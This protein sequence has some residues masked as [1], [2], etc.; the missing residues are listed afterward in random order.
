MTDIEPVTTT[1]YTLQVLLQKLSYI[2]IWC[3][4]KLNINYDLKL[5]SFLTASLFMFYELPAT[6]INVTLPAKGRCVKNKKFCVK[7][8][9][10]VQI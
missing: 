6:Q 8:L 4:L 7:I 10:L 2:T 5:T 9:N 3:Y 1:A